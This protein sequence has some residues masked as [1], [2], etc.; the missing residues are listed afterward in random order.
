MTSAGD[1]Y[2]NAPW[3]TPVR[4]YREING[5]RLASYGEAHWALEDGDFCNGKINIREI[6]YNQNN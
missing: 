4:D 3:S 5:F 6:A 2:V 1:T